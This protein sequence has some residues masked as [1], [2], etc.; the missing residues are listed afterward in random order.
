MI[1]TSW[2]L[3]DLVNSQH[4][5]VCDIIELSKV[6]TILYRTIWMEYKWIL[7]SQTPYDIKGISSEGDQDYSS[8][9]LCLPIVV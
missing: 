1:R 9:K 7:G 3:N 4:N 8:L 5:D 6:Y 2:I